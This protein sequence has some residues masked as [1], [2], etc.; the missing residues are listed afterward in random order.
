MNYKEMRNMMRKIP[1]VLKELDATKEAYKALCDEI[2]MVDSAI[3][4][5]SQKLSGMPHGTG[6]SKP[7]ETEALMWISLKER[8]KSRLDKYVKRIDE[9]ESFMEKIET[10]L[11]WTSPEQER[12][13]RMRYWQGWT[14][15]KVSLTINLTERYCFQLE[16]QALQTMGEIIY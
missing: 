2:D 1:N 15:T 3:N 4:P 12:I 8:Y 6:I 11:I 14:M 5:Q 10:A 7:T 13:L 16:R 9:L